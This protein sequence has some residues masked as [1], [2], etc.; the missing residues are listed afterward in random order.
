MKLLIL[1]KIF[2]VKFRYRRFWNFPTIL[3]YA[4]AYHE[5]GDFKSKIYRENHN[6]FGMKLAKK[7]YTTA[8]GVNREHAVYKSEIDSIIDFFERQK[9]FNLKYTTR[10]N[11]YNFLIRTKYAEDTKYINKLENIYNKI[12]QV[13]SYLL[14]LVIPAILLVIF[15][16]TDKRLKNK[17]RRYW[18]KLF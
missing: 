6:L 18:K 1:L 3:I 16:F 11:Y 4:Q 17:F 8:I 9:D 15:Y 12:P 14:Y 5:T 13:Y 10:S 7:R 2:F